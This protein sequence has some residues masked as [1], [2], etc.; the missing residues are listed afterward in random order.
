MSRRSAPLAAALLAAATF[1]AC[2]KGDTHRA[3]ATT[4]DSAASPGQATAD[5]TTAGG[6]VAASSAGAPGG[7]RAP[8]LNGRIPVLEYHVIGGEKNAMYTRTVASFKADLEEVYKR[9][10]RPINMSQLLD[11]DFR[12]VPPGMSPVVF[13]FDDA[14]PEQFSYLGEA[15]KIDPNSG[16][17]IWLDFAKSHPGW[18]NRGTFCM[19]NG[20]AAGHN[21]FGDGPKFKGQQKAWRFQKV[22][23]LN[24]QGFELCSHTLWHARLDKYSDA[25]VQE[26]IARNVM[27]IDSAV[28]GYRV[29]SFALPYGIWPKNR[30][31]AWSGSWT[32]P[33]SKK[34]VTYKF[35]DVMEVSGGPTRSPYDPAFNPHSITRIEAVG[36]DIR[37]TLERLDATNNRF[38]AK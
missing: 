16:V 2:A 35:D 21:F 20:G 13:V 28:P 22:Q 8:N 37:K 5:S 27:G 10:Y 12:D 11:K 30:A 9:G 15:G 29:R 26:Q 24:Q 38:V 32:D 19:L 17:G 31:L 6:E 25:V 33:K 18:K 36:D 4:G 23:W 1:A 34:T 3:P 14:S 7:G